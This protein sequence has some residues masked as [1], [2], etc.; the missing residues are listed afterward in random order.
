MKIVKN[1][2]DKKY[3]ATFSLPRRIIEWFDKMRIES[4]G[5]DRNKLVIDVIVKYMDERGDNDKEE[6]TN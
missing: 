2:L 6:T 1:P 5:F 3:S 4:P